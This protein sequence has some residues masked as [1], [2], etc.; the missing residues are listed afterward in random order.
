MLAEGTGT[1][2]LVC[3]GQQVLTA[4]GIELP[5]ME[6]QLILAFVL[7]S[8]RGAVIAETS[9][10]PSTQQ[11]DQFKRLIHQRSCGTPLAYLRGTQEF[12]GYEF[13]VSTATLIPRPETELLVDFAIQK[14]EHLSSPRLLDFGTGS[15]CIAISILKTLP[16]VKA[17]LMDVSESALEVARNNADQ[18]NVTGIERIVAADSLKVVARGGYD[19]LVSNPPYIPSALINTLQR[20]VRDH[21]PRLA[22]DGGEDGLHFY[23]H[24]AL[25]APQILSEKGWVAV[26]VG[27]GQADE[28]AKNFCNVGLESIVILNDLAG[29]QRVVAARQSTLVDGKAGKLHA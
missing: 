12:Y 9:P 4:A 18:L 13:Q 29:I 24:I 20:E 25:F 21:E 15:G 8:S 3:S 10:T 1:R 11:V 16:L 17:T 22:L 19:L 14:L 7:S 6:S 5:R 28:V 26:E 2:D 23:R 27:L